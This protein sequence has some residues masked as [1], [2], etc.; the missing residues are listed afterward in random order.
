MQCAPRSSSMAPHTAFSPSCAARACWHGPTRTTGR[1]KR[2]RVY[3]T[4]SASVRL[5]PRS[6]RVAK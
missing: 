4:N 3:A 1:P 5:V 6:A 2:R